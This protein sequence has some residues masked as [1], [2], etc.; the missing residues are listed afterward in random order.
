VFLNI[1][2]YYKKREKGGK[3][4]KVRKKRERKKQEERLRYERHHSPA[5]FKL[6]FYSSSTVLSWSPVTTAWR[7]L[8]LRLEETACRYEG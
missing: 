5:E 1:F 2:R 6:A 3:K 7:V 4:I 8:R